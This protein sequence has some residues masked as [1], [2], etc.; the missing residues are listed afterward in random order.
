MSASTTKPNS[1]NVLAREQRGDRERQP[2]RSSE[3]L[4]FLQ[5]PNGRDPFREAR[6]YHLSQ[7]PEVSAMA[8]ELFQLRCAAVDV[9]RAYRHC[10]NLKPLLEHMREV[11][12]QSKVDVDTL[13]PRSAKNGSESAAG[14][15]DNAGGVRRRDGIIVAPR[16]PRSSSRR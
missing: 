10:A 11:L 16:A 13:L 7:Q 2:K 1:R 5:F 4:K 14:T 3:S 8:I 12:A 6:N 9:I 15:G